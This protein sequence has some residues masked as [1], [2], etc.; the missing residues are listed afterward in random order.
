MNA[1]GT[2]MQMDFH[3]DVVFARP[4]F[5][6]AT[7][8]AQII[9]PIYDAF[10]AAGIQVPSDALC[11][12]NGNTIATAKVSLSL[13]S[14]LQTFE[15]RLDGFE[16]HALNLRSPALI[17]RTKHLAQQFGD[18]VCH[19]LSSGIPDLYTIST[20]T[21]LTVDGGY[22]AAESLVRRLG[23][24]PE[25]SDPFG[26]GSRQ[27]ASPATFICENPDGNWAASIKIERSNYPETH[28]FLLVAVKY[29]PG[30]KFET[31]VDKAEHVDAIRRS[32]AES[33]GVTIS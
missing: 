31:F 21:W 32:V 2:Q 14:G 28:L 19:F 24:R 10:D 20:P 26:I 6:Q 4:A 13:Y 17:E 7:S 33:I 3:Y 12:E 1:N 23:W 22:D 16:A 30:S 25:S 15:V 11:V 27:V 5:S 29:R 18:T 8:F 9:E